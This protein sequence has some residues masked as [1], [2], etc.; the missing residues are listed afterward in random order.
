MTTPRRPELESQLDARVPGEWTFDQW[1]PLWYVNE[2]ASVQRRVGGPREP[3]LEWVAK[4]QL[5]MERGATFPAILCLGTPRQR[6]LIVVD[7]LRIYLATK[8]MGAA[9]I[10]AYV[11][12]E[13]ARDRLLAKAT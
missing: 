9:S 6:G 13:T 4:F 7:G 1:V 11:V 12:P 10:A 2:E 3:D 5:E 8:N